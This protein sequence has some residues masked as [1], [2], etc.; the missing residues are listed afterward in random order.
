MGNATKAGIDAL[1]TTSKEV[2][3]KAAEAT[4]ESVKV[5]EEIIIP[6]EK[7]KEILNE[8]RHVL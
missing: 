5:V 7:W 6:R 2:I 3:Q 8:L 1:K 4:G